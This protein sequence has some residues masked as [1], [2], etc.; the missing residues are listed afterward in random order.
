M[1]KL[2][3]CIKKENE[4]I[5]NFVSLSLALFFYHRLPSSSAL[6]LCIILCSIHLFECNTIIPNYKKVCPFS[7]T[8]SQFSISLLLS[9]SLRPP[10]C[11]AILLSTLLAF[12][13]CKCVLQVGAEGW[14][15]RGMRSVRNCS[16]AS[17]RFT[18]RSLSLS[19]CR[20]LGE[21]FKWVTKKVLQ[22]KKNK[23]LC[24]PG[25]NYFFFFSIFQV[26][27]YNLECAK[28]KLAG[29]CLTSS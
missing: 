11:V 23:N 29:A 24:L 28:Q 20:W 18:Y 19:L 26:F 6:F 2:G 25:R 3:F 15:G 27:F 22:K 7:G 14:R 8:R 9:L 5:E 12:F 10:H 4:T 13:S 1:R 17:M 16:L 21:R